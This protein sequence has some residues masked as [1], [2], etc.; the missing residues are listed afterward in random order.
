M[1][2][3][4]EIL[5][6]ARD[7]SVQPSYV[8]RDYVFGWLLAGLY[9]AS[10][11]GEVL[12]LK[13]GNC[14]RKAYFEHARYSRDLDFAAT[15]ALTGDTI[16]AELLR[17]IDFVQAHSGVQFDRDRTRVQSKR[18]IDSSKQAQEA[19]LY[20]RDFFG[21]EGEVIVSVQ[22]DV[23]TNERIYLPIQTRDLIHQ[24]SDQSKVCAQVRCIQ[25]EEM[26]AS[27]L[28][29]LLQRRHAADLY[30]FVNATLLNPFA[31]LNQKQLVEAF[32]KMTIFS[33]GPGVVVDLLTGLPFS[34][35]EELWKK[36]LMLPRAAAIPFV[37][38]V[39]HF[40]FSTTTLFGSLP[41][42]DSE[43]AFFP[44]HVRNPIMD[45]AQSKTLLKIVYEGAAREVEPYSLQYKTRK[46]G[47]AREYLYVYD[48]TGG[49]SGP[50]VKSLVRHNLQQ[51][52]IT[53]IR[54]EPRFEV[55]L[56]KA[57]EPAAVPYFP[58]RRRVLRG[59]PTLRQGLQRR[60]GKYRVQCPI[61]G[62]WFTR[63]TPTT[64]LN[65]HKDRYGNRCGGRWGLRG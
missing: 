16:S 51:I 46:D 2:D 36:Y 19:R 41:R 45:A 63:A 65:P 8:Q 33:S 15:S 56:S 3:R 18:S 47:V 4:D 55:E 9:S 42:G 5:N 14:F 58:G 57:G 7:L 17:I 60:S 61:C 40:K 49:H 64:H 12:V 35:I 32:L 29:C 43:F 23:T 20:F 44:S 62:K 53:D 34:T 54:F 21:A 13:G 24:Y 38:A 31:T 50:G 26:L 28:K 39:E 22:M 11:L 30:D 10:R 59:L 52:A 48:R 27:K 37:R 1:I 25:L 6:R